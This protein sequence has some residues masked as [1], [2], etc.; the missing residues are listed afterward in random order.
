MSTEQNKG[1]NLFD[2][3]EKVRPYLIT[4]KKRWYITLLTGLFFGFI[5]YYNESQKPTSYSAQITYMLE[6]EILGSGQTAANP[7][8]A[9]ISGQ[10]A[11]ASSKAI[12]N[13][14]TMSNKLIE[15][16]L[17]RP[18]EIDKRKILLVNYYQEFSGYLGKNN[19]KDPFWYKDTYTIGSNQNLDTRL[20]SLSSMLKLS[21]KTKVMESGLLKMDLSSGD[22]KFTKFFLEQHLKT[23]SDFYINKRIEKAQLA[24]ASIKR[25][26]DSLSAVIQGKEYTA[27]AI[28]D[29]SF[30]AVM[31]RA[32]VPEIQVRKDI[33]ILN[34]QYMESISALAA[35][36]SEL[37]KRR[38]FISVVDDVRYPLTSVG[39]KSVNQGV[40]SAI[41][42]ILI[43]ALLLVGKDFG[44]DFLHKQKQAFKENQ[45]PS[46]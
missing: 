7:L 43:G 13:D 2:T 24:V 29:N 25:R 28:I 30:G 15:L 32:Q 38:P 18:V 5:G 9:A 14:L 17:M 31:R 3:I 41:I 27:A 12:M 35:A 40:I 39:P 45:A 16:T 22:E 6:D 19:T 37:E 23:I 1:F 26:K 44:G 8:M 36:K 4:V 33:T 20:R 21:L 34:S 10:G 42:G 11:P 46:I